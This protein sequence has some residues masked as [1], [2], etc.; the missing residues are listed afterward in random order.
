M[1]QIHVP[2]PTA[3]PSD[4]LAA[5]IVVPSSALVLPLAVD[6]VTSPPAYVLVPTF[7]K[8]SKARSDWISIGGADQKPEPGAPEGLVRF[9]FGGI[10]TSGPDEGKIRRDGSF[11]A[12]LTPL[13]D[14]ADLASSA[15]VRLLADGFTAEFQGAALAAI[16]AGSTAGISNDIYLRTPALLEDC[17]IRLYVAE[18]QGNFEDF[19][20]VAASYEE[21]SPSLGDEVLRTTVTT[22]R[23]RLTDF[24]TLPSTG[25]T[26]LRLMP[27]FFQV[28]TGGT[29]DFLPETAFVRL[30]FQA[31]RDNGAGL[32]DEANPLTN[33][34]WTSDLA[35]FNQIPAGEIQF[36]RYE[37]EFDLDAM[38]LGISETT[39]AVSLEFLKIP[40]VF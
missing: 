14:E 29:P 10:E 23:G 27:R 38:D 32:P 40:F 34:P 16:R 22:E 4:D 21:G 24:N 35:L 20:I 37:V 25:T 2:N 36:F 6:G 18:S 13:V 7:G 39:E 1:I 5:D 3:E 28:Q 12:P 11:V 19:G 8:Q 30:R 15:S 33:P 26:A 9:L 31:A 17:A